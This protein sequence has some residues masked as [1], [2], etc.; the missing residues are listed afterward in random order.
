M[1]FFFFFSSRRRHTRLQGDWSSDV[2]SSDLSPLSASNT[3]PPY[4][5]GTTPLHRICE[6]NF[7]LSLS[8]PV[9]ALLDC[10][11]IHRQPSCHF[12]R[13]GFACRQKL[14]NSVTSLVFHLTVLFKPILF[15][16]RRRGLQGR[17]EGTCKLYIA[18]IEPMLVPPSRQEV[19]SLVLGPTIGQS[20]L[21]QQP[22]AKAPV[23]LFAHPFFGGVIGVQP[24]RSCHPVSNEQPVDQLVGNVALE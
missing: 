13:C 23:F 5:N 14:Q 2:C 19:F 16:D 1:L 3:A 9:E 17:V 15:S 22:P 21:G 4:R 8:Q 24:Y 12:C 18:E 6:V 20:T 7:E 10:Y 11:S